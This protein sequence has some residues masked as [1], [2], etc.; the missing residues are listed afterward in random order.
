MGVLA[1]IPARGGSKGIPRKNLL[2]IGGVPLIVRTV[3][4]AKACRAIEDVV[5]TTDDAGIAAAAAAHGATVVDRPALL[6]SDT[7]SSESV[8]VHAV[9]VW[10]GRT[11]KAC[12]ILLLLQNT[13]PFHDPGDMQAVVDKMKSGVYNSCVTVT[14]TL[15]YFWAEGSNGWFMPHQKRG[16][17]QVRQP[18]FEEAGSIYGV[19]GTLFQESGGNLFVPPVGVVEVPWWRAFEIDEPED[20]PV[21]EALCHTFAP[22]A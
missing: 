19:R 20:I 18:W 16:R 13:S 22:Q 12:D 5:V 21:A 6:A 8:V 2:P 3:R 15:R 10:S 1:V 11:R 7:A 14:P 17:R 9:E 4:A